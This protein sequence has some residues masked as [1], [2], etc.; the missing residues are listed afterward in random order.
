ML[1]KFKDVGRQR[2]IW[3]NPDQIVSVEDL[4]MSGASCA[5]TVRFGDG[6]TRNL[7]IAADLVDSSIKAQTGR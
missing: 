3:I 1:V 2:H 5:C 6:S 4:E 7:G